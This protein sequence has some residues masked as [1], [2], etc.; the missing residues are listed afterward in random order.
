MPWPLHAVVWLLS[1]QAAEMPCEAERDQM[2]RQRLYATDADVA[3]TDVS[4]D[5][6]FVAFV[7]LARLSPADVN[8]LDDV[9]VLDRA[10]NTVRLES[11]TASGAAADGSCQEPRLSGDGRVVVFSTVATN[12]IG[13]PVAAIGAQV[14]RRDRTTGV[15][16][17]VSHTP[18]LG[19]GNGWSGHPDVSDDGRFVVFE[20]QATDLVPGADANAGGSDVYLF[21]AADGSVVRI[22]VAATGEQSASGQS[23]TPAISGS[24][25]FVAFSST[26]LLDAAAHTRNDVR[27]RNVYLQDLSRRVSR[28]ISATQSGALPNGGSYY[29]AIS[30]DG[31]RVAF[32]S[33]ATDLEGNPRG[34]PREHVYL[35]DA[36]DGRLRLLSRGAAGGA[37]DGDSRHP[38]VSGDG[39]YVVFGSDASNLWCPFPCRASRP[40]THADL[41]L[42]SDVYRIDTVTGAVDRVSGGDS[43]DEPW[44]RS[45][46]GAAIDGSG[47][48]V[49]FSSRQPMD[50]ADLEDD[51]DL[52]VEVLPEPP[53]GLA[54]PPDARPCGPG[55]LPRASA[56]APDGDR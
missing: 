5:G 14:V 39:R 29:P 12:L 2:V 44:W 18:K 7:S 6:R 53:I 45:S 9:Y 26:A 20:S 32:V 33:I 51:D 34:R 8:T 1:L 30:A 3:S 25:R 19:P 35:F 16:T 56:G 40:E 46:A 41:N 28:R 23:S 38:A 52:F 49:A 15:T 37:A 47:R 50:D 24:G 48:V 42:V 17:L 43:A 36:D 21:D 54:G 22:S 31:R 10:A 11:A 27:I 13:A 4:A 55:R